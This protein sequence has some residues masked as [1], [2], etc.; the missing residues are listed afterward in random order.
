MKIFVKI[1]KIAGLVFLA[2]IILIGSFWGYAYYTTSKEEARIEKAELNYKAEKW[3]WKWHDKTNRIQI[4]KPD[5]SG[6]SYLRKVNLEKQY[7]IYAYKNDDLSL[8]AMVEFITDC[9]PNTEITTS[10]KYSNGTPKKLK[11]NEIGDALSLTVKWN[12]QDTDFV[13]EENLD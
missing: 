11:C 8:S 1:L 2:I 5:E 13:W 4:Y 7:I 6:K 9:Q 3:K 12:R 10:Q